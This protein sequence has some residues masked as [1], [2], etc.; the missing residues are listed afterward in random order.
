MLALADALTASMSRSQSRP[1]ATR[2]GAAALAPASSSAQQ[3]RNDRDTPPP[4]ATL[5][6]A[7]SSSVEQQLSHLRGRF[8]S[9]LASKDRAHTYAQADLLTAFQ[10]DRSQ[11]DRKHAEEIEA[12]RT[13]VAQRESDLT[14]HQSLYADYSQ[15]IQSELAALRGEVQQTQ[16]E[17]LAREEQAAV[18][19]ARIASLEAALD[20]QTRARQA[21]ECELVQQ[22][23]AVLLAKQES[24]DADRSEWESLQTQMSSQLHLQI[25]TRASFES[26]LQQS[27][28]K[29][30][31]LESRLVAAESNARNFENQ[32][33]QSREQN[34]EMQREFA[35]SQ[36]AL[37]SVTADAQALSAALSKQQR[38][39]TQLES[40]YNTA[41]TE[42][43]GRIAAFKDEAARSTAGYA[44]ELAG[45]E[46]A[47][48]EAAKCR[49][50][51]VALHHSLLVFLR[52]R[53]MQTMLFR[54]IAA[55]HARVSRNRLLQT[56]A[57]ARARSI[58]QQALHRWKLYRLAANATK[59]LQETKDAATEQLQQRQTHF[60]EAFHTSRSRSR[61]R[62]RSSSR[63]N[64]VFRKWAA[65][66]DR[67]RRSAERSDE[68]ES[69]CS[70]AE[71]RRNRSRSRSESRSRSRSRARDGDRSASPSASHSCSHGRSHSAC[72]RRSAPAAATA[73]DAATVERQKKIELF[74]VLQSERASWAAMQAR[75]EDQLLSCEKQG[76]QQSQQIES[77]QAAV[78]SLS[79]QQELES[80]WKQFEREE[81]KVALQ[82]PSSAVTPAASSAP[83]PTA[84][85][86][87]SPSV[88]APTISSTLKRSPS[89]S[90]SPRS[91]TKLPPSV[92]EEPS[93]YTVEGR[94]LHNEEAPISSRA[95][96]RPLS[97]P[98]SGPPRASPL[99][100]GYAALAMAPSPVKSS[101]ATRSA[102]RSL[103]PSSLRSHVSIPATGLPPHHHLDVTGM[104][105]E[106]EVAQEARLAKI[107]LR[108]LQT[109]IN[110]EQARLAVLAQLR[111][112]R[113]QAEVA[114]ARTGPSFL[115]QRMP[116]SPLLPLDGERRILTD[117]R[118]AQ[119]DPHTAPRPPPSVHIP[120]PTRATR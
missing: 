38:E 114:Q 29:R 6:A 67:K 70:D 106:I 42:S 105:S 44:A 60:A 119:L 66:A 59:T 96:S 79:K 120:V 91:L 15:R 2:S 13:E 26:R 1:S 52:K 93:T 33:R 16:N 30:T 3:Q 4:S 43:S 68:E 7:G 58:K 98:P 36:S 95:A 99:R 76:W 72:T 64:E 62:E 28:T 63:K 25:E 111:R 46:R 10:L 80:K 118:A 109:E 77:L 116:T 86:R 54:W 103:S 101:S 41:L 90:P 23:N 74:H 57:R 69:C 22:S 47:L 48:K 20:D 100:R 49:A 73:D 35:A 24:F 115:A 50:D 31:E 5:G 94:V 17:L 27:E 19:S 14:A 61:S 104:L 37:Q 40:L 53:T 97:P 110:A 82:Q 75:Y 39:Y 51:R 108:E 34:L 18:Q 84:A 112:E 78:E 89:H 12:L 55:T 56:V 21:W 102:D 117:A 107:E 92:P 9:E 71:C 83:N 65:L 8:D 45:H 81:K 113:D 88:Q 11:A 32:A 85:S 87:S